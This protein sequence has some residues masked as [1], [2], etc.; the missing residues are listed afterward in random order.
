MKWYI[1]LKVDFVFSVNGE[2][3]KRHFPDLFWLASPFS[4]ESFSVHECPP[5]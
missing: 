3:R 5:F 1:S 2:L 4:L